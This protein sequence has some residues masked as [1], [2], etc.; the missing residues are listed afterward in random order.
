MVVEFH[1]KLVIHRPIS[2]SMCH[3]LRLVKARKYWTLLG[4]MGT[5]AIVSGSDMCVDNCYAAGCYR[6]MGLG[7]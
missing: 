2:K 4:F 1:H 6:A 5:R 7:V 3:S